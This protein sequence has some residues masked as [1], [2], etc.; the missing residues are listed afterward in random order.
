MTTSQNRITAIRPSNRIAL[1]FIICAVILVAYQL[2]PAKPDRLIID[3]HN[4]IHYAPDENLEPIDTGLIDSSTREIDLA[5]YVLTDVPVM[6]ALGRA[7]ARGVKVRVYLFE[8]ELPHKGRPKE[9]ID[10]LI[11]TPNVEI[12]LKPD[13]DPLMHIKAFQI[14]S[15]L[16]RTGSANFSNAGEKMQDNDLILIQSAA[17]A[18]TFKQKFD[19]MWRNKPAAAW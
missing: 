7:A 15:R 1:G 4:E 16:L 10:T 13:H 11:A 9:A 14:D 18:E 17:A 3:G 19:A 8:G 2:R 12:R 6:E 5:A